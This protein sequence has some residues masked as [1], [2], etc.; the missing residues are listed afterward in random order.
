MQAPIK[1]LTLHAGDLLYFPRGFI[2]EASTDAEAHSLHITVSVYQNTSYVD[3]LEKL[4]PNAIKKASE[5]D[6]GF[7]K[8]LPLNYLSHVGMIHSNKKSPERTEILN[9][10][11]ELMHKL[12]DYASVD[13]A[14]DQMGRKFMYEALPPNL[15]VSEKERSSKDD[16]DRMENGIVKNIA[17]FSPD[18]MVRFTRYHTQRLVAEESGVRIYYCTENAN[19]YHGEEEQFLD[20]DKSS[21]DTITALQSIYPHYISIEELPGKDQIKKIQVISDLWERGLIV[22]NEPLE[23]EDE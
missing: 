15:S 23:I 1:E 9:N 20:L 8:G 4:L 5:N 19:V 7:R 2:H 3:L 13:I 18:T 21:V 10:V 14:A 17:S 11:K 16:G 6:I 12:V 22:T